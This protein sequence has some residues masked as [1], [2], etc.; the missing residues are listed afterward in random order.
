MSLVPPQASV[1][2]DLEA[3]N[4]YAEY[5]NE[6][7]ARYYESRKQRLKQEKIDRL[8]IKTPVPAA[9][10]LS[11]LVC[12]K[13]YREGEYKDHIRGEEHAQSVIANGHIY[14]EIDKVID[15]LNDDLFTEYRPSYQ[16]EKP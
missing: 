1:F 16:V 12:N 6:Y 10:H 11:C 13:Q 5:V 3:Y 7:T 14:G 8:E 2:S 4:H 9:K 15:Q